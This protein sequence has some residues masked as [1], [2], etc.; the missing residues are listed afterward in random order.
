MNLSSGKI[1]NNYHQGNNPPQLSELQQRIMKKLFRRLMPFLFLL[2]VFSFLDRINIGFAGLTMREDLVLTSGMFGFATSLFYVAYVIFGIPANVM[3]GI[4]G[5]RRW[6]AIIMIL[7]GF[8]STATM[9]AQGAG[10]L[11]LLRMLV[12]ITEAGF[13]PGML[14]YLTCWFPAYYRARANALF[15]VAMPVTM[16]F[17]SLLSGYLLQLD[18]LLSLKGWQWLFLLEGFPSVILG[19][20][21]WFYLDDSPDKACWLKTDEKQCLNDMLQQDVRQALV[22][23]QQTA[24]S[25][26]DSLWREVLTPVVFMYIVAYF[27]LTN[28]LSAINIWT[29]QI[30]QSF[31]SGRSTLFIGLLAAIPQLCTIFGMVWWGRRSDRRQERKNHTALPYF[32][33]AAGWLLTSATSHNMVQLIGIIMASVGSFTAMSIFWTTPDQC[34]SVRARAVGIALIN[35]I[36]NVGSGLSP[37]LIGILKDKTGSFNSGL[38]FMTGLLIAGA[39]VI[40]FIPLRQASV[41]CGESFME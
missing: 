29:P 6:I 18:G 27:C 11:Y 39:I 1:K 19:L 3:L 38:Y 9:L 40:Y 4:V 25:Q 12:G 14:V 31:N 21:A 13:L 23:Q 17:G 24:V 7:W 30:L 37:L 5:A 8:A 15:M 16:M 33:S 32:F 35:A 10:S 34:I 36:G 28:T 26:S 2:F 20:A 41:K 22:K